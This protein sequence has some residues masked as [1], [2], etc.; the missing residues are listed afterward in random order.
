MKPKNL[1]IAFS[2]FI[3]GKMSGATLESPAVSIAYRGGRSGVAP[4]RKGLRAFLSVG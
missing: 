4:R 1:K 2:T 3:V